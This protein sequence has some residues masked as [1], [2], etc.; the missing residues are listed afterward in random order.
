MSVIIC[1]RLSAVVSGTLD[2][3][4]CMKVDVREKGTQ[5]LIYVCPGEEWDHYPRTRK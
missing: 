4:Y 1:I 2:D 5:V 3:V